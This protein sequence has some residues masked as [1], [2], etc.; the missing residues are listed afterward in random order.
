MAHRSVGVK[1]RTSALLVL[2]LGG[3]VATTVGG[4]SVGSAASIPQCR[5]SQLA[6]SL[7]FGGVGL[8]HFGYRLEFSRVG[9]GTCSLS[10]YVRAT[11]E[12]T[13]HG[14]STVSARDTK[15]GYLGGL[16]LNGPQSRHLP[17]VI[18]PAS[19]GTASVLIEGED[20]PI[21]DATTCH[22]Y[23]TLEI[24]LTFARGFTPSNEGTKYG[25]AVSFDECSRPQVHPVVSGTTGSEQ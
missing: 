22:V 19:N 8:G 16:P 14:P 12:D 10:G 25:F 2:M 4:A 20:V 3:F 13:K 7:R 18:L 9:T 6:V 21:G 23:R 24:V 17:V 1:W 5:D 11:L 15:N